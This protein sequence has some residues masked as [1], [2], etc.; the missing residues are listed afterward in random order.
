MKATETREKTALMRDALSSARTRYAAQRI[1]FCFSKIDGCL[2][3][4]VDALT[5]FLTQ[6]FAVGSS[7]SASLSFWLRTDIYVLIVA[8]AWPTES[9][10]ATN[11]AT[12]SGISGRVPRVPLCSFT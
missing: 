2:T 8:L 4:G 3:L 5:T 11:M 6:N 9:I 10:Y 7:S 1:F 12:L